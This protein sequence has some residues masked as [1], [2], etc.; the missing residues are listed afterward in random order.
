MLDL[1]FLVEN[2]FWI[3][4]GLLILTLLFY[5]SFEIFAEHKRLQKN[6]HIKRIVSGVLIVIFAL[7][8][9]FLPYAGYII[10]SLYPGSVENHSLNEAHSICIGAV[11]PVEYRQ[12]CFI[13]SGLNY[14]FYLLLFIGVILIIAGLVSIR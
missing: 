4:F 3:I 8:A 6:Y 12:G 10:K 13:I 2:P 9:V 11:L 7:S 1:S 5:F 14:T